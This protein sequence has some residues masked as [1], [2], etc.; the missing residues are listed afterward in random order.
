MLLK[1]LESAC[2]AGFN[3][4]SR[5]VWSLLDAVS[6]PSPYV[7]EIVKGVEQVTDAIRPLI[8]QKK[9][10]RNYLDK[11]ARCAISLLPKLLLHTKSRH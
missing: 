2:E 9:Y 11:A 7:D 3:A 1:E 4:M 10:F 5:T 6:G 8:E